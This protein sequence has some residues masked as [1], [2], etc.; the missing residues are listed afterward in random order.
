MPQTCLRPTKVVAV[1]VVRSLS[2]AAATAAATAEKP[3]T[4]TNPIRVS[5]AANAAAHLLEA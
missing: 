1:G 4:T 2:E 3:T 5:E